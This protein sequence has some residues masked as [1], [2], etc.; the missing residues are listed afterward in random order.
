MGHVIAFD[1]S[2]G[3]SRWIY[4]IAINVVNMKVN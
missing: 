4:M 3:K 2:M 1:V